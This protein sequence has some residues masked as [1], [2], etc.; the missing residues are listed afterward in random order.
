MGNKAMKIVEALRSESGYSKTELC[1]GNLNR[2]YEQMK[3]TDIKVGV[4]VEY[5]K[6]MGY[7]LIITKNGIDYY[8]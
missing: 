8:C 2:Y 1:D 4:F 7:R 6:K 3:A 5:L